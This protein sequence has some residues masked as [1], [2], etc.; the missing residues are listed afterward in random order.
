MFFQFGMGQKKL[1]ITYKVDLG[2]TPNVPQE[3]LG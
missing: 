3:G 2:G 1:K